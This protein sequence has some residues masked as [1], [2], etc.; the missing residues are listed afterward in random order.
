MTRYVQGIVAAAN[1][2]LAGEAPDP[3]P[4]VVTVTKEFIEAQ[5]KLWTSLLT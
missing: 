4:S 1:K 5:V 2:L 3:T